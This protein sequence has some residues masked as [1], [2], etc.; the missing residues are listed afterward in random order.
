[1]TDTDRSPFGRGETCMPVL[2]RARGKLGHRV[3]P[4]ASAGSSGTLAA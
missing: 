1:M 2:G 3:L 4:P